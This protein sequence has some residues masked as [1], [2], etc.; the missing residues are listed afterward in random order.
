M[1]KRK[2]NVQMLTDLM[3]FSESGALM[4]A[5]IVNA[6]E[7]YAKQTLKAGPWPEN[8]VLSQEAWRECAREALGHIVVHLE[9]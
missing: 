4:Q 1:K 7:S 8:G 6:I 5:F 3:E 2:T 9:T